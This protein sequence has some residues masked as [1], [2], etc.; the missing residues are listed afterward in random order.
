M[1]RISYTVPHQVTFVWSLHNGGNNDADDATRDSSAG[2]PRLAL[3][4]SL[5]SPSEM[6]PSRRTTSVY[7]AQWQ[8]EQRGRDEVLLR[9]IGQAKVK[10]NR[11]FEVCDEKQCRVVQRGAV[12]C[13]AVYDGIG[14]W[15][16]AVQCDFGF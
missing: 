4:R 9:V 12:Y 14:K 5:S 3:S 13:M 1:Y 10:L 7:L 6:V 2:L 15:S 16:N 11:V 8:V